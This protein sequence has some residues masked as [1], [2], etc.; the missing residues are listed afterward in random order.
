MRCVSVGIGEG[1][2]SLDGGETDMPPAEDNGRDNTELTS[3][4]DF[5]GSVVDGVLDLLIGH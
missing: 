1:G 5:K 3:A 2:G 4:A